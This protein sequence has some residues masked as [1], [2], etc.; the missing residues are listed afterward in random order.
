MQISYFFYL[1]PL[2]YVE[3]VDNIFQKKVKKK[4]EEIICILKSPMLFTNLFYYKVK[5][6]SIKTGSS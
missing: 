6:G 3:I 1:L 5:A 4:K 2:F